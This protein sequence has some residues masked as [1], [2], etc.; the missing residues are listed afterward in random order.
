MSNRAAFLTAAKATPFSVGD[1]PLPVPGAHDVV[2]RNYAA[3]INPVDWKVQTYGVIV[4]TFP[5]ILGEDAA[6]EV[7]AVG[8]AVTKFKKGDRVIAHLNGLAVA[9][10]THCGFQLYTATTEKLV[11]KIP[12]HVS[13]TEAGVL[14]LAISTAAAALF[15]Q[16]HLALPPPQLNPKPAGKVVLVWGGSSSVGSAAIQLA[17]AAGFEV[18]TT[19]SSHNHALVTGLGAKYVFD[20]TKSSVVDDIVDALKGVEFAGAFDAI[21]HDD[22]IKHSA[23]VASRLGGHK[24]VATVLPPNV[25]DLPED[26]KLAGGKSCPSYPRRD[27]DT[28]RWE[29]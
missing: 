16:D 1:A 4:T 15:Q 29:E 2:V 11:A 17:K 10:P 3:A 12:D 6:G 14:P 21:S 23:Q 22:T 18:A 27:V 5:A 20:H 8:S 9:D 26:V 7:T 28:H 25:K 19:A 24:F 13:F